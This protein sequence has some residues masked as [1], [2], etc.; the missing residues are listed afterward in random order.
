MQRKE[1]RGIRHEALRPGRFRQWHQRPATLF[2]EESGQSTTEFVLVFCALLAM[3]IAFIA[4]FQAG[5]DGVFV[6]LGTEAASHT[7][8]ISIIGMVQDVLLY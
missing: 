2:Q 5:T 6:R 3:V 8:G 1:G 7:S 4:F